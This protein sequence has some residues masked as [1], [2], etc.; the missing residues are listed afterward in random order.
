MLCL[1]YGG[2][3]VFALLFKRGPKEFPH[4][5]A[6]V[7]DTDKHTHTYTHTVRICCVAG[8]AIY[9]YSSSLKYVRPVYD[10]VWVS[11]RSTKH[12]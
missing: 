9:Q 6:D 11:G 3:L 10:L 12:D 5:L 7:G 2:W 4:P 1:S 8:A